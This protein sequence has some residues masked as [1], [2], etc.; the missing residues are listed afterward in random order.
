[1]VPLSDVKLDWMQ[2]ALMARCVHWQH[3]CLPIVTVLTAMVVD[4]PA[5]EALCVVRMA[6][7]SSNLESPFLLV[8]VAEEGHCAVH[9]V[10]PRWI[11]HLLASSAAVAAVEYLAS[12]PPLASPRANPTISCILQLLGAPICTSHRCSIA[13]A[14]NTCRCRTR[15]KVRRP[16]RCLPTVGQST[17]RCSNAI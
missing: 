3:E 6:P 13:A 10:Q 15:S 8:K 14:S 11:L 2:V 16:S 17:T 1:M 12:H 5:A 4:M 7:S 9:T